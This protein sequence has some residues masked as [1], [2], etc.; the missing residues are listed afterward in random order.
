MRKKNNVTDKTPD[1]AKNNNTGS[2]KKHAIICI[3][4]GALV[5]VIIALAVILPMT[6]INSDFNKMLSVANEMKQPEMIITDMM[7]DSVFSD[8]QGEVRVEPIEKAIDLIKS[9]CDLSKEFEYS[10]KSNKPGAALDI[11]IKISE[12]EK[13]VTFYIKD[14]GMYYVSGGTSYYFVPEND[15]AAKKYAELYTEIC[16]MVK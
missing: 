10:S 14:D 11:R 12:G 7:A 5:L 16:D 13:S 2:N 8:V 15:A 6:K 4:I 3:S 1:P 9:L